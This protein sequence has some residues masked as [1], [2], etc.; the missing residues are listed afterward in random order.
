MDDTE[1]TAGGHEDDAPPPPPGA[2]G[3]RAHPL[4]CGLLG[5]AL[6]A[7]AIAPV[8][9]LYVA[10][11]PCFN[12]PGDCP[13]PPEGTGLGLTLAAWAGAAF[14]VATG[15]MVARRLALWRAGR[16]VRPALWVAFVALFAIAWGPGSV[17]LSL[18]LMVIDAVRG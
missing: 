6:F 7:V 2:F 13:W 9:L 15:A 1:P 16:R 4:G 18:L 3:L 5:G 14:A 10:P 17:L 11:N 12:F 8:V